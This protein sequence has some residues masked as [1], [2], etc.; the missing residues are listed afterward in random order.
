MVCIGKK[1]IYMGLLGL[2]FCF[3]Y[4]YYTSATEPMR[5]FVGERAC[6]ECHHDNATG[7]QFNV[8]RLSAHARAH[9]V[10]AMEES[11]LIADLSGITQDVFNT[12][13]CLGCHATAT[14]REVWEKNENF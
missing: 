5:F 12:P 1:K 4:P 8:W 7:N 14:D 10:L 13:V 3:A 6:R 11:D 9:A 2:L